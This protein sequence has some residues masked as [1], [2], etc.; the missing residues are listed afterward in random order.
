VILDLSS[1]NPSIWLRSEKA[2]LPTY[3]GLHA[4]VVTLVAINHENCL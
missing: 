3:K 1:E 2:R 4:L